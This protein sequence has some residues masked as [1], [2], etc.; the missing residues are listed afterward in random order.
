[1]KIDFMKNGMEVYFHEV[2]KFIPYQAISCINDVSIKTNY[3][4]YDILLGKFTGKNV[5]KYVSFKIKLNNN[6]EVEIFIENDIKS[7]PRLPNYE[8]WPFW[9]TFLISGLNREGAS[10]EA[11]EWLNDK[12]RDMKKCIE[13]LNNIRNDIIDHFN[14]WRLTTQED[15]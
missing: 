13:N 5:E 7:F 15:F 4:N 3:K 11:D 9:K 14:L 8:N 6:E 2:K 1:M 12:E 10:K